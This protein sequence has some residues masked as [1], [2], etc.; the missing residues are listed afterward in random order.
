M[1][2]FLS[3]LCIALFTTTLAAQN[4]PIPEDLPL[5]LRQNSDAVRRRV[6]QVMPPPHPLQGPIKRLDESFLNRLRA[7]NRPTM[8][9]EDRIAALEAKIA[10]MQNEIEAQKARI[11]QLEERLD[12]QKKN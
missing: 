1:K 2:A 3:L 12:Q 6:E 11:R 9:V 7:T 4:A 10:A 5:P 8:S